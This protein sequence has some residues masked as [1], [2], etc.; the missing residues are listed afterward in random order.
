MSSKHFSPPTYLQTNTKSAPI[1]RLVSIAQHLTVP[2]RK[3]GPVEDLDAFRSDV[4]GLHE[5]FQELEDSTQETRLLSIGNIVKAAYRLTRDGVSLQNRL[6]SLGCDISTIES[7]AIHE[8]N[9]VS[10]YWRI[11]CNLAQLSRCREY[12]TLFVEPKLET[13]EPYE[14][15]LRTFRSRY[16]HA[17]IQLVVHYEIWPKECLPRIIGASKHAC[18]LCYAFVR[19]HEQFHLLKSHGQIYNQWTIPDRRQYTLETLERFQKALTAVN[20]EVLDEIMRA[21]KG[22]KWTRAFPLQSLINLQVPS[23]PKGS[24]TTVKSSMDSRASI[25]SRQLGRVDSKLRGSGI[26]SFT[27]GVNALTTK[28]NPEVREL[29]CVVEPVSSCQDD[30]S[31]LSQ[32]QNVHQVGN[33]DAPINTTTPFSDNTDPSIEPSLLRFDWLDLYFYPFQASRGPRTD[34]EL[35]RCEGD[36]KVQEDEDNIIDTDC[37]LPGNDIHI[38]INKKRLE[39]KILFVSNL[40]RIKMCVTSQEDEC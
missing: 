27:S 26:P 31:T 11:C 28:R 21:Q 15:S 22:P 35:K 39:L 25:I 30:V 4:R 17:E 33:V 8:I 6:R 5:S 2:K 1:Q 18:Y 32:I 36:E 9:K 3:S 13:L 23:I 37:W 14:R 7:R 20:Q 12:R 19:A 24:D 10:N 38:P 40:G 16:V 34:I 29:H